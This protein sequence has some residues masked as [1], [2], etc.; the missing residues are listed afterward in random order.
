MPRMNQQNINSSATITREELA[1]Y[2]ACVFRP[3]DV[4]EVRRLPCGRST[5][6]QAGK[7]AEAADF[8]FYDNHHSQHIYVGAN[9][10]RVRGGTRAK[11]VSCARCLFVDFDGI[12]PDAARDRWHDAGL[13][14]PTLTIASGHGVH[15]YWRLTKPITDMALWSVLQKRLI[16]LLG[17]DS[18]IHDPARIMRLPGFINH[19]R[20]VATC[21]IIDDDQT[22]IYNLKTLMPLLYSVFTE[23]DYKVQYQR[24]CNNT[25][26]LKKPFHSNISAVKVAKLTA[27]KWP[28][29]TKGQ[30]NCKAFQRAAF[31]VKNLA[32]SEKQAWPI[33]REWNHK[34]IP[35]L[36]ERELSRTLR[37]AGIYGRQPV[38]RNSHRPD[39]NNL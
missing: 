24:G 12:G 20:P 6:H 25:G 26:Q 17:S 5:W 29:V 32:L 31:L 30:R 19:K 39:G 2:A 33:L 7:L 8:L 34:N 9:P 21:R 37:N 18:A 3:T 4:I 28:G 1:C 10:R 13:P 15:A 14:M 36:P 11:D 38:G 35:P 22:R 27:D 23:S 16:A